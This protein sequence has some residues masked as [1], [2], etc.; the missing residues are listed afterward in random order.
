M[1]QQVVAGCLGFVAVGDPF[2]KDE[3]ALE[4]LTRGSRQGQPAVVRLHG[5]AC[6]Q[7]IRALS[8]GLRDHE[9]EFPG[10]VATGR[11]TQEIISL[12]VNLRAVQG[13]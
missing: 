12:D 5:R 2:L 4:A 13:G 10:L 6:Y 3:A 1:K 8:Q 7:G 11:Q 9:L